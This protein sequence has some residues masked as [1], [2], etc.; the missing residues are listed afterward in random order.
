MSKTDADTNADYIVIGKIGSTWGIQGW[1]KVFSFTEVMMDIL[2]YTPWYLDLGGNW[3]PIQVKEGRQHGKGLV[4]HF[5]GYHTPEEARVL[6]GK[7]I[8]V[9]RSQLPTL[10]EGAYYW[11][12]LEGL[13]VIDQHGQ[14]LGPVLYLLETGSNDVLVIKHQGKEHAIPYLP[15]QIVK[16]IDLARRI[17]RVEWDLI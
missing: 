1:L 3:Q 13:M 15:G 4:A 7:K 9:K 12:D 2:N 14:E 10:P 16:D 17:M 11:K 6:T 8:A 5:K